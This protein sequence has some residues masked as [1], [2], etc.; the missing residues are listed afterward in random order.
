MACRDRSHSWLHTTVWHTNRHARHN[1]SQADL[2]A[3]DA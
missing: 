3:A 2:S 1:F